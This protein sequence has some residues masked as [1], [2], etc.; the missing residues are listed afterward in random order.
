M[1]EDPTDALLDAM[2]LAEQVALLS[3]E[4]FWS[5]PAIPRLGI[6]KLRVTDGPNGARGGGS[7]IGGVPSAAFPVGIALGA[8][9]DPGIVR[10]IGQAL[11]EEATSKGAHVLLG[12]T[13][14]IHRSVTNG[15]NFECYAEDPAL[16]AALAVAYVEGLQSQ[17]VAAT[18]KHFAGN[19]SEIERTTINSEID[20]R[21]LR[22]VHLAPFEAVAKAGAWAL[23]ASYNRLNGTYTS[24]HPWLLTE[25]LRGDWGFDG[26]VMSDWFGSHSTAPTVNAGLD[27]EMPGPPR[28]RGPKLVAAL[29]AGEV[30]A[31]TVRERARAVLRL[32]RRTGALTAPMELRERADDR[33]AHRAL[34][35][36]AGAEATVL[37]KN[38][39]I[40]PLGRDGR[41]AVIGPNARVAQIMGGGSA[42][43]NPHYRVSPWD[44]LAAALGEDRLSFAEGCT[45]RRF[46][47][48]LEGGFAVE[49]FDSPDLSGPVRHRETMPEAQAFWFG[50]VGGGK[51]D[52]ARYSARLTGRFTPAASGAYRVGAFAAGLVRVFLDGRLV[53]DAWSGWTPGSTFF[54]EGC[55]EVVGTAE[56]VA[57]RPAEVV[58]EF[59]TKPARALAFA[60][61]RVGIGMPLGDAEIAAAVEAARAADTALVFL[62]RNGE[63]DT[64]GSDLPGIALP[65]RQDELVAAVAAAN[66]RTVV[67]L[68]TGGPAEMPWLDAVPAVLQAWY[69]GQEAGNAI[70]D[71][72]L[73]DVEPGGRLPQSFPRAWSDNPTASRDPEVYP[74][75]DGRVRYAEGVFV[76]Y[77]HYGRAGI[78]PLFPFGHGLGYTSFA[79]ESFGARPEGD[80][81]AI[82]ATVRNTG[83]RPGATVLQVYVADPESAVPRPPKE[84]KAFLKLRLEPGE[85]RDVAL[86][87]H[88]RDLAFWDAGRRAWRVE[89]GR[90]D[91]LAGFSAADLPGRASITRD[92]DLTLAP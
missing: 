44:G 30:S 78:A 70:A 83:A 65:G 20:E 11:A 50:A 86:T 28:D 10:E 42:Q 90:F 32:M 6:G 84:L 67:V 8:T 89:A 34:I 36:R 61:F 7:L 25:V 18:P 33:P 60:A 22:E 88:P 58:I 53:A 81:V 47:P 63:W 80:T 4:D 77:R 75:R 15:R 62:G 9:W 19:E 16:A 55:D 39:G 43:L 29:E 26:L 13:I 21:T 64:E 35:R 69:P 14:N 85:A 51:V 79:L 41:I 12:P 5:L 73:G 24:E 37:L 23:M 2:T 17:G 46:E 49:F 57:G 71:V 74:G 31:A 76:G 72:L 48:L 59:A 1:T 91:I 87:L 45:N 56:L 92:T 52:P 82:T 54:E 38:D 40:L 27:L 3:G 68:Q 66:P